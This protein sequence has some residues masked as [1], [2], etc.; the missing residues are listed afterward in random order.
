MAVVL[1]TGC[2]SG[3]GLEAALAFARR[4]DSVCATMRNLAKGEALRKRAADEG[5]DI[6]ISGTRPEP[7]SAGSKRPSP[8]S[9]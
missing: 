9:R 6:S 5:L 4:G 2:S 7:M 8:W 3:F 1:I